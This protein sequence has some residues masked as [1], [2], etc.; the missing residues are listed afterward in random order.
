[1]TSTSQDRQVSATSP[2]FATWFDSA[3]YH[4]L[5][6]YRDDREASA[7]VDALVGQ[8]HVRDGARVLDLGCGAGRHAR[9]LA[10]H[11]CDVT[12]LDL[13]AGSIREACRSERAHLH[14]ARH[15]M[16][17]PF[18]VGAFDYVFN[19]FTSFGYFDDPSEHLAVIR[20]MAASLH[21]GGTLVL[22]YLNVRYAE[23]HLVPLETRALDDVTYRI[24]RWSDAQAFFKR[25]TIDDPRGEGRL[26]HVE[27]VARLSRG[28]FEW[29]LAVAGLRLEAVFGDYNL[30][31]HDALAS[32]R[33]ILV[34]TRVMRTQSSIRRAAAP[35]P[36][37]FEG[38]AHAS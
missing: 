6:S 4:K 34:A 21:T 14:F 7:F 37:L 13:S 10:L 17:E 20:N 15:D 19:L 27:R 31:P 11:G 9:Q 8:L 24:E 12:G 26:E 1:M 35:R 36:Q 2:W 3:H 38:L 16:R 32:P 23:A 28:D 18:G 22:D 29:M 30:E 25:I 33:M 5:Y